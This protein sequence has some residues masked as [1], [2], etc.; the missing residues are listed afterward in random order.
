MDEEDRGILSG[1]IGNIKL[2]LISP[3]T[4]KTNE[5]GRDK[6]LL[7]SEKITSISPDT[8]KTKEMGR[9]KL[10]LTSEKTLF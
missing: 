4:V 1:K 6:L 7:T 5:M 9:Y 2:T 3:D 8:V 10:P